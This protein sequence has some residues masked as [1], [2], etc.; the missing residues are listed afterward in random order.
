MF[1][2]EIVWI[3]SKTRAVQYIVWGD[4]ISHVCRHSIFSRVLGGQKL[5][6]IAV[7]SSSDTVGDERDDEYPSSMARMV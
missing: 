1:V 3:A 7:V 5:M 4:L 6:R 2:S